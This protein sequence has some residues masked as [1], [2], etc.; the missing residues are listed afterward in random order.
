MSRARV[1]NWRHMSREN[2]HAER[3]KCGRFETTHW[4]IAALKSYLPGVETRPS[5]ADVATRLRKTEA[6]IKMAVSRLKQEYGGQVR[7]EIK[8]TASAP[9]K[10][11]EELHYLLQTLDF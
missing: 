8:R 1:Q 7:A 5:Y 4:S 10:E 3:T 9:A 11:G 2:T 6:G